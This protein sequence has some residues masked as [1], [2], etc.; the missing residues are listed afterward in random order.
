[1]NRQT[2]TLEFKRN[3]VA[4]S[5]ERYVTVAQVARILGIRPG[6]PYRSEMCFRVTRVI[7]SQVQVGHGLT[8]FERKNLSRSATPNC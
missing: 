8:S 2:C 6:L 7:Q 4:M 5:H 3:A 1:M